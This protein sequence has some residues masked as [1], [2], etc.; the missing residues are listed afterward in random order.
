MLII[1]KKY[2]SILLC[3]PIHVKYYTSTCKPVVMSGMIF[4]LHGGFL[5]DSFIP[6]KHFSLITT[7]FTFKYFL[8]KLKCV[9]K[10]NLCNK[11]MNVLF[12]QSEFGASVSPN[13]R[14]SRRES[15]RLAALGA[16]SARLHLPLLPGSVEWQQPKRISKNTPPSLPPLRFIFLSLKKKR[17]S[18]R[19]SV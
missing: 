15:R 5:I 1:I 11:K 6:P 13:F 12:T 3:R 8:F 16:L 7:I 17:N 19:L 9:H 2:C 10:Y 18:L 14:E 4:A